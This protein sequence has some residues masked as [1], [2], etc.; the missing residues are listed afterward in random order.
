[1]SKKKFGH[2]V[3]SFI[4][5]LEQTSTYCR[6]RGV[7]F[8]KELDIGI[9]MDE[10]IAIDVISTNAGISQIDLAKLILMKLHLKDLKIKLMNILL[11]L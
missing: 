6:E 4:Y 5:E 9:A 10:Y 3:D 11:A 1:M 8:F 7:Q 2:F